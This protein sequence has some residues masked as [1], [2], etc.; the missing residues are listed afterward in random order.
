MSAGRSFSIETRNIVDIARDEIAAA[1][2]NGV[3]PMDLARTHERL[4]LVIPALLR[5]EEFDV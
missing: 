5:M 4:A 1:R 3:D 2:E